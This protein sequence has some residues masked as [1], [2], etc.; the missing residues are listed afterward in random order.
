MP[1][2]WTWTLLRYG[3]AI[4]AGGGIGLLYDQPLLGIL[5]V[6]LGL[7]VWQLF[8][9]YR[10]ERW[11]SSGKIVEIPDGNGVWPPVFAKIL[12]IKSKVKRRGKRFRKLVKDLR[13]STEAFPDGG[14]I[15]NSHHEIVNFNQAARV[16]LGL[17]SRRD[18]GQRIE[19]LLRY[20]DFVD[21]LNSPGERQAVEIPSP[22]GG[23]SWYSCRLI[24]YGPDQKLLLIRD[25][26]QRVKIERVRRDFVANASH[27]LRS[28]LTVIMGYLDALAEDDHIP[29]SW[30]QP[31]GVMQ[32]QSIRMRRLVEDLLQLSKLESGQSVSRENAVDVGSIVATARKEAFALAEH[33]GTIG[34]DLRSTARLL[35]EET[36][37]QS[38]V[39]NL[40]ANAARYTPA[41]GTI[42]I[43]WTVDA[44]GGHLAV[45]DTGIGIAEEDI[46]RVTERFYRTDGGRTRQRGGTG[47]GLAIVKHALRRHDAELEIRSRLGHGSTFV[48][49]FPRDRLALS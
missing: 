33:P 17:K 18:R 28:P 36:E 42:T 24:P 44:D 2:V 47:L 21:Y 22:V 3:V 39:S 31:I 10:L 7:L 27:E 40:V 45:E 11:L 16:M 46:A 35:G 34:I 41:N 38:V 20:P 8:N 12:F 23:E 4:I 6:T 32:E 19:N 14:V 37:L 5:L 15:L 30:K 43:S 49:H 13:A 9:L 26:S 48:C 25:V 29:D 1:K